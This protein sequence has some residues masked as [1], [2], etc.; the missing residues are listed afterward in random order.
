MHLYADRKNLQIIK[1]YTAIESSTKGERPEF[2]RMIEFIRA[3][4]EK[5]AVVVDTVDRL[6]RSF[7]ETPILNELLDK[8]V[9]ELHFVKEGNVLSKDANSTQ[10]LM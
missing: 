3:Q 7:K 10:K 9:L 8:D 6:Q 2:T 5:I 4:K 1:Q